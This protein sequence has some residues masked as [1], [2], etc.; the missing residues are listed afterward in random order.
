MADIVYVESGYLDAGYLVYTAD[1]GAGLTARSFV[2]DDAYIASDYAVTG[3]FFTPE[4]QATV[5]KSGSATITV[6]NTTTISA[7]RTAPG[8]AAV[9]T[10]SAVT[11]TSARTRSSPV[12]ITST[13]TLAAVGRFA[14]R[15]EAALNN[16]FTATITATATKP[17]GADLTAF[18]TIAVTA[19]ANKNFTAGLTVNTAL[20]A[21]PSVTR[22]AGFPTATV[23]WD[24]QDSSWDDWQHL[25]WDPDNGIWI[26]TTTN[27]YA[28][29]V[30]SGDNQFLLSSEF[31][32]YPN[33]GH[34]RTGTA[35]LVEDQSLLFAIGGY[36]KSESSNITASAQIQ[37]QGGRVHS[38]AQAAM[39]SA[40]AWSADA[41]VIPP[42]RGQADLLVNSTVSALGG[43]IKQFSS[44]L[45]SEFSLEASGRQPGLQEADAV[46]SMVTTQTTTAVIT[47]RGTANVT[48]NSSQTATPTR[49]LEFASALIASSV[50]S[51]VPVRIRSFDSGTASTS[52]V[53]G[54]GVRVRPGA[55]NLQ[56]LTQFSV[57]AGYRLGGNGDLST[58][59]TLFGGGTR[60][61]NATAAISTQGFVLTAG[62]VFTIDPD[63]QLVVTQETRF[64]PVL[65]EQRLR[66]VAQETRV[67]TIWPESRAIQVPQETRQETVI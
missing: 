6:V 22:D 31:I 51:I 57:L 11:V 17:S 9:T 38:T 36:E 33:G 58:Q 66:T 47:A 21:Q 34:F 65:P 2:P 8:T 62:D 16:T 39:S 24:S 20:S 13:S 30:V 14:Q 29:P 53:T 49:L 1:A 45:A 60:R 26:R 18:D 32:I 61:R 19:L 48:V 44:D 50:A 7:L 12:A 28:F 63:F 10:A 43:P 35:S 41:E 3:Y 46:L 42:T 55:G 59:T 56:M 27:L 52:T 67:N 37:V 23:T 4:L 40:F 64:Y 5:I 54:T 15:G 25:Y